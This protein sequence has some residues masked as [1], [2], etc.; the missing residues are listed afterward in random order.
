MNK[1]AIQEEILE[2]NVRSGI[3]R[4]S[5]NKVFIDG[6]RP[7]SSYNFELLTMSNFVYI[8]NSNNESNAHITKKTAGIL[9]LNSSNISLHISRTPVFGVSIINSNNITI[10]FD[11]EIN[12]ISVINSYECNIDGICDISKQEYEAIISSC[13]SMNIRSSNI[14]LPITPFVNAK[15]TIYKNENIYSIKK[16]MC[17]YS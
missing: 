15:F 7:L 13:F 2:Y 10:K 16:Y 11:E 3:Q 1:E 9:I 17:V 5:N 12:Y 8:F 6:T 14:L 4:T